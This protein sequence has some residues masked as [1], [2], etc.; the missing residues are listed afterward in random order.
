[1]K[2]GLDC[3]DFTPGSQCS[4]EILDV[5][6]AVLMSESQKHQEGEA[7]PLSADLV[8]RPVL[9]A[10]LDKGSQSLSGRAKVR[11]DWAGPIPDERLA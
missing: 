10:P 6:P 3:L 8:G 4:Q 11:G 5:G 7:E 1:M 2:S 9:S